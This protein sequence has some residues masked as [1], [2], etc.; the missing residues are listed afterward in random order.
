MSFQTPITIRKA[1]EHIESKRY[2]LP[3]IQ[4]EFVWETSQ[5]EQLFDS[6]LRGYPIGSFLFWH[7]TPKNSKE[8]EF[9]EFFREYHELTHSTNNRA[10]FLEPREVTAILD[11]QQRLTALNIGLNGSFASR[12]KWK[13]KASADAYPTRLLYLNLLAPRDD[14]SGSYE[15][16]FLSKEDAAEATGKEWFRVGHV[17]TLK[18]PKEVNAYLGSRSLANHEFASNTLF[19][20]HDK[21]SNSQIINFYQEDD[22][23]LDKVL[24]IFIRVNSG[25]TELGYSDLLLSTATAQWKSLNAREEISS[26]VK[27]LNG[28]EYRFSFDKDFVMK[29]CLV[30]TEDIRDIRFKVTN[31]NASNTKLIEKNWTDI[32]NALKQAVVLLSSFGFTDRSLTSA[33]SVLPIAFYLLKRGLP[34]SYDSATKYQ[35][36]RMA[37][38][39]WLLKSLLRGAFGA[40][41]DTVLTNLRGVIKESYASFPAKALADRLLQ[42]NR[43]IRFVAEDLEDL[44]STR[45]GQKQAFLV[46]SLLYP[47]I[48]YRNAFHLDHVHPQS[49]FTPKRLKQAGVPQKDIDFC[50][51]HF[52]DLP[53]LQVLANIPNIEKS[54]MSFEN[55]LNETYKTKKARTEFCNQQMIPDTSYELANFRQFY[56]MRAELLKE[57][58]SSVLQVESEPASV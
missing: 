57:E 20:L 22:Q 56:E 50:M 47:W 33:N 28:P 19:E 5:I 7:V 51:E 27:Q 21:V 55:W 54:N 6:V 46:L 36:D 32:S 23:D 14:D 25:G 42:M 18:T 8:Y 24:Q 35:A 2:L 4:R 52:D 38:R 11:G 40:Q 15:F 17:L 43:P 30:L 53:N 44:I 39:D 34:K 41:G 16:A 12:V 10:D 1:L 26:L 29:A 58:L 37:V 9:Y 49:M 48:D 3:A 13:R 45:Y 31:F